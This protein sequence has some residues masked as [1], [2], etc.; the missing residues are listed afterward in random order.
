MRAQRLGCAVVLPSN[1]HMPDRVTYTVPGAQDQASCKRYTLSDL[2]RIKEKGCYRVPRSLRRFLTV[3]RIFVRCSSV[4]VALQC[5]IPVHVTRRKCLS[6]KEPTRDV[7]PGYLAI[8]CGPIPVAI[9]NR[10]VSRREDSNSHVSTDFRVRT[11]VRCRNKPKQRVRRSQTLK[12]TPSLLLSNVRSLCNKLDEVE[13]CVS[14]EKPDI[15]VL[16]E[17][18]L[19]ESTPDSSVSL[20]GYSIARKD[21]NKKG[22]GVIIYI[23]AHLQF[24]FL[25]IQTIGAIELC[26]SEIL[27]ILFPERKLLLIAI[28]H[29]FWNDSDRDA[30]AISTICDIIEY[31]F[32]MSAFDPSSTKI[33]VCGD[34]ND[35][36][37]HLSDLE[38]AAGLS[39]VVFE[40]TRG[41]R[42]LDQILTNIKSPNIPRVL[43]P[44][45][46]SDHAVVVWKPF[47]PLHVTVTKKRVRNFSCKNKRKFERLI[48]LV[49]WNLINC[50]EDSSM[51]ASIFHNVLCFIFDNCFPWITV[52]LRSNDP[53]WM[54]ASL[55]VLINKRDAAYSTRNMSRYCKLRSAVIKCTRNLKMKYL[56]DA[57]KESH[58]AWNRIHCVSRN[59]CNIIMPP[60]ISVNDFGALFSSNFQLDNSE[61]L[62]FDFS[63]LPDH[64]LNVSV[65]EVDFHLKRLKKGFGGPDGI[66]FWV[67]KNNSV[68]LSSAIAH[69]FNVSF[70]RG[71]CPS[72]FKLAHVTPIPKCSK[73]S[74]PTDFRPISILPVLSKVM[75]KI[76]ITRW[77]LPFVSSKLKNNQFAYIPGAGKG[78]TTALTLINDHILRFLDK[79]SGCVRLL[80]ADFSKA[81]DKLTFESI[82]SAACRFNLPRQATEFL[83]D[84]LKNRRQR[85]RLGNYFSE[86]FDVTSGVPQGSVVGPILFTLVI[87]SFAPIN[88][89]SVCIKFADDVSI[90]HFV[91]FPHDDRLQE[92]WRH[93]EEWSNNIGLYLNYQKSVIMNFN[94]KKSLQ[95]SCVFSAN[96]T[97]ISCVTS[98][99]LLGVTFSTNLS[100]N[101]HVSDVVSKCYRRFFIL[102]N[103]RR[104][105][106]PSH[107][108]KKCYIAF[109][110]AILTY[111]F[112]AFCNIPDYLFK[113]MERVERRAAKFF[114]GSELTGLSSFTDTLCRK[115]F[116]NVEHQSDH[117]LKTLFVPRLP[118]RTNKCTLKPPCAKSVRFSKSFIRYGRH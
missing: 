112:P 28:Y 47:V 30:K 67:F 84:F 21:R 79:K 24:R 103:L 59:N 118:T 44:F 42:T 102:R 101:S 43:T 71:H 45:G 70:E 10:S 115:L 110:R 100:W 73:P 52:R 9:S 20:P 1:I 82:I 74:H 93:L 96:G 69:I 53:P 54:S 87:D 98:H 55:K 35:L 40:K 25:E 85:V 36:I 104:A 105:G 16:T 11:L 111:S 77:I 23:A 90:L 33:I 88:D 62:C 37:D 56:C 13:S 2:K 81:F 4:H 94:T 58:D 95:L 31:V 39:R 97:P 7:R 65:T 108:I 6:F 80:A 18:W 66:P 72:L 57:E 106:C 99:K 78:T 50:I 27:P 86:W 109:I 14:K 117:A 15:I 60:G 113:I 63:S 22:G 26:D 3:L 92:E 75:E 76:V 34:F 46:R 91:S 107:V 12:E 29:P 38:N 41:E 89:N 114:P 5:N 68:F 17:S 32:S 83:F 8:L 49:N 116:D 64:P 19:D 48:S 51:A 61:A